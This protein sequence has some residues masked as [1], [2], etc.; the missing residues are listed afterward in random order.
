VP[1]GGGDARRV[2]VEPL[3]DE[4]PLRYQAWVAGRRAAVHEASAGRVGYLHI[5]DM[6]GNGWAELHRDLRVE[7]ARDALLVDVRDNGGG[8]TSQLVLEKIGRVVTAWDVARHQTPETYPSDSPRG[9]R[10]LLANEWAGSDGDIVTAGFRQRGLGP[11]IGM[12]TWGGVIG[13]DGRYDLVDHS[14]VTQPR[15]A[16]WFYGG[17]GWDIENRGVA[18]DIEVPFPPQ[19][20]AAGRDP[21]LARAIEIVLELLEQHPPAQPPDPATRP[22]RVPP[23]LPPRP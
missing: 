12:R 20:W 19:D 15:Y 9:A 10:V 11:V 2:V 5:P 13:I 1:A 23:A 7:V 21:Q 14:M 22:S 4:R 3:D 16:F 17:V 8:H 6:M 18:P